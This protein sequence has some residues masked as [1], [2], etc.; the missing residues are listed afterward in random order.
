[1]EHNITYSSHVAKIPA[2]MQFSRM[3]SEMISYTVRLERQLKNRI[4]Q[5]AKLHGR[6]LN[7]HMVMIFEDYIEGRS[8]PVERA[9]KTPAL[10]NLIKEAVKQAVKETAK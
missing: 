7:K 6:S 3:A 10:R 8:V 4:R 1:M 9:I 2:M 5:D